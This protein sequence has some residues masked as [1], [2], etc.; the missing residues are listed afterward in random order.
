MNASLKY[1]SVASSTILVGTM[2]ES[3]ADMTAMLW[4]DMPRLCNRLLYAD[5]R[6]ILS[7]REAHGNEDH[8]RNHQASLGITLPNATPNALPRHSSFIGIALVSLSDTS[9]TTPSPGDTTPSDADV[10]RAPLWGDLLALLSALI[11]ASYLVLFKHRVRDEARLDVRLLFGLMGLVNSVSLLPLG[12]LLHVVG[13]E[14]FVVP[15][16][17]RAALAVLTGVRTP[18]L[19]CM[20]GVLMARRWA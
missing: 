4:A 10:H 7:Y 3:D 12:L 8:R 11:G 1:T 19:S 6:P 9:P 5:H 16:G 14:R 15:A 18:P 20:G 17:T 2:G 13:A